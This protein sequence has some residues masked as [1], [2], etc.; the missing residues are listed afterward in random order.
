MNMQEIIY[1]ATDY[2]KQEDDSMSPKIVKGAT[3]I[4]EAF[5][6]N[7]FAMWDGAT[8]LFKTPT[9]ELIARKYVVRIGKEECVE[10]RP[11]NKEFERAALTQ[12]QISKYVVIGR[13]TGVLT[14]H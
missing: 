13:V 5:K 10:L 6:E 3:M 8:Y 4:I 9:G 1:R 14:T 12:E 7:K 11:N 2:I